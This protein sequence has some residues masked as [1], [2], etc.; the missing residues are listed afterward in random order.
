MKK[1]KVVNGVSFELHISNMHPVA[2]ITGCNEYAIYEEYQDPSPLKV[3]LWKNWC[4]WCRELNEVGIECGIE[5]GSKNC[6]MFTIKGSLRYN[7]KV[8]DLYIT[9]DHNRIYEHRY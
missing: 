9:K 8:Y 5:I 4:K 6:F 2:P 3:H 1:T 7:D